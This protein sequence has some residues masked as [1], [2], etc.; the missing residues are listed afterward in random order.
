[1]QEK[2]FLVNKSQH[3]S[4]ERLKKMSVTELAT[5]ADYV[6]SA[7]NSLAILV[8]EGLINLADYHLIPMQ[9]QDKDE[10]HI[11]LDK[12][13]DWLDIIVNEEL[14]ICI[15]TNGER[16]HLSL[17][18]YNEDVSDKNKAWDNDYISSVSAS[19]KNI[20][21]IIDLRDEPISK[22][23]TIILTSHD[24]KN[25]SDKIITNI[26]DK[27]YVK[28]VD[29]LEIYDNKIRLQIETDSDID[30]D[31]LCTELEHLSGISA[32]LISEIENY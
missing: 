6:L 5:R 25:L 16:Y 12:Q 26:Q 14:Q 11:R 17:Y 21:D 31:K 32:E 1:M 28:D 24:A 18:A 23:Y 8:N 13:G 29:L 20:R 19:Y 9:I 4:I 30:F 3:H 2:L 27:T 22:T 15:N 7:L 10:H